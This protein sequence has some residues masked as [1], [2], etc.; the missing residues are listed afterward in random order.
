MA[1]A[2]TGRAGDVNRR[3]PTHRTVRDDF[4]RATGVHRDADALAGQRL[5][6]SDAEPFLAAWHQENVERRQ[7]IH[8][9]SDVA[10]KTDS[11]RKAECLSELA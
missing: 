11:F 10:G 8:R 1:R 6:Q 3:E 7:R 2:S 9:V 4:S 5:E